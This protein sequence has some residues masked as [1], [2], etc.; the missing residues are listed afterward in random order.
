M[1][2]RQ[3]ASS[4]QQEFLNAFG[5]KRDKRFL[6]KREISEQNGAWRSRTAQVKPESTIPRSPRTRRQIRGLYGALA[7]LAQHVSNWIFG[8]NR[9][10]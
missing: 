5:S 4:A 1:F 7:F 9:A 8:L 2:W 10:V 3:V 6:E